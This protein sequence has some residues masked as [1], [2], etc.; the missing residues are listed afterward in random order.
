MG[1][2]E[3][4]RAMPAAADGPALCVVLERFMGR[5]WSSDWTWSSRRAA[6]SAA[7]PAAAVTVRGIVLLLDR[8]L[9]ASNDRDGATW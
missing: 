6:P 5:L 3:L 9:L 7:V 2:L 4:D 1:T 8:P